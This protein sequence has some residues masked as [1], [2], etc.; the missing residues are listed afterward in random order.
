M[1]D[2]RASLHQVEVSRVFEEVRERLR[3]AKATIDLAGR[4][5]ESLITANIQSV[6]RLADA[7]ASRL[8]PVRLGARVAAG[9]N[10]FDMLCTAR[11]AAGLARLE[12]VASRFRLASGALDALS[13]LA[14][15]QRGYALAQD[16][17]G[18]LIRD[19]AKVNVGDGLSLRLA[20]GALRCRVEEVTKA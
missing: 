14:V 11:D 3:N 4:R 5:I 10:K 6:R 9:R 7:L 15:L 19:A 16:T 18:R 13:P 12:D 1:M 8:S 20:Q 2:L 17:S